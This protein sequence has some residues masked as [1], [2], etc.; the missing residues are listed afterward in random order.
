[1]CIGNTMFFLPS[2]KWEGVWGAFKHK[3]FLDIS[4]LITVGV[5]S[6]GRI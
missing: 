3:R 2:F 1:M 6:Y 4:E 5:G